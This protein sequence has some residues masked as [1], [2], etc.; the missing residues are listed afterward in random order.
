[1]VVNGKGGLGILTPTMGK[2]PKVIWVEV[3]Q[4]YYVGSMG[5]T[6]ESGGFKYDTQ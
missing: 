5:L 4:T 1:V 2:R 3:I 6:F